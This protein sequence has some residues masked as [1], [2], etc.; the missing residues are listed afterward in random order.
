[1]SRH[2]IPCIAC[3]VGV[4]FSTT[5]L[6][7]RAEPAHAT[8]SIPDVW[9]WAYETES[10][11][12]GG[13]LVK[14][15]NRLSEISGVPVNIKLRPLRRVILEITSGEVGFTFLFKSPELDEQAVSVAKV[16]DVNLLLLAAADTD[17]PLDLGALAGKRVAYIRGTYLGEAF[18]YDSDIV[19][20]PVSG[21]GQAMDLL[22]MGRIAAI[23][24]SDH[25]ILRTIEQRD[26]TFSRFRYEQHVEG[27][28]AMMYRSANGSDP[29]HASKFAVAIDAMV[30]SGELKEIFF[31]HD[32]R[33][34][35]SSLLFAQ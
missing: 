22:M 8:F 17:Y 28:P 14:L 32:Y 16:M 34:P 2:L 18:E 33:A 31:G 7:A 35:V 24:A 12:Q 30:Q 10:G 27:Q 11:G 19:K 26:L 3:L 29:A 23:L 1:M 6:F 20:V 15:T 5:A 13:S 4:L 25:N 9:P 21:V